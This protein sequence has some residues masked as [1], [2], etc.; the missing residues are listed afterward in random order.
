MTGTRVGPAWVALCVFFF[1]NN[2]RKGGGGEA[3]SDWAGDLG[4]EGGGS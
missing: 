1:Q 4:G 3:L 2:G